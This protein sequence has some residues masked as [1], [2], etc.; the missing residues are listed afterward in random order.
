M[1]GA[2]SEVTTVWGALDKIDQIKDVRLRLL[3][4][5]WTAEIASGRIPS[6][7]FVDPNKLGDLMGWLFLFR[8]ERDP[9]RFFYLLYGS[10]LGRRLNLDLTLK[11]ADEHP[12]PAAREGII[13][14]LT[15]VATTGR[16]HRGISTRRIFD[17]VLSTEGMALPLRGPDGSIDHIVALQV[18]DVPE[19]SEKTGE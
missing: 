10:K 18:L 8:V 5:L 9:L 2:P 19:G 16:P 1:T 4:S 11:Y 7:D 15:A 13:D 17:Q 3:F 6:K 14:I 12:D